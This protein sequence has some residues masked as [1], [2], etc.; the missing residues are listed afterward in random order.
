LLKESYLSHHS[1]WFF[2]PMG[3]QMTQGTLP[4]VVIGRHTRRSSKRMLAVFNTTTT[5]IHQ[6]TILVLPTSLRFGP[7]W[8]PAPKSFP[9]GPVRPVAS[10]RPCR[11]PARS[12]QSCR[13]CHG[14]ASPPLQFCHPIAKRDTR[15][16]PC[17]TGYSLLVVGGEKSA[18]SL[19][20]GTAGTKK[21]V[22]SPSRPDHRAK[23]TTTI[24]HTAATLVQPRS[25][26]I[27][28]IP[29]PPQYCT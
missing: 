22:S 18:K 2:S 20:G 26:I 1:Q 8:P 25:T 3:Q 7:K 9:L 10:A 15:S 27:C 19:V 29:H 21:R 5:T 11:W 23:S 12:L 4:C 17:S 14:P 6:L 24:L 28:N 13:S 16:G